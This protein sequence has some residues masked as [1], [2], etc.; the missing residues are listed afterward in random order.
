MFW[1][2]PWLQRCNTIPQFSLT[3]DSSLSRV[4]H[5]VVFALFTGV[6]ASLHV[7]ERSHPRAADPRSLD[8]AGLGGRRH[9]HQHHGVHPQAEGRSPG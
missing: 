8:Q 7:H 5:L 1:K 6:E 2:A 3:A 9:H 4:F